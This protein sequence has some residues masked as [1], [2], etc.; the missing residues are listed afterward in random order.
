MP[1][2][3]AGGDVNLV[4]A[5]EHFHETLA[6]A[7]SSSVLAPMLRQINGRLHVLRIRDF[8]DAERV[9]L[10][11]QQHAAILES[12]LEGDHRLAI[13]RL[14]AHILESHA[15]VRGRFIAAQAEE[16]RP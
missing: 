12:L 14:K 8:I 15:F 5:D 10:T 3:V 16:G 6:S 11:F 9:A 4:L 1:P 7:G 2:G 13:A